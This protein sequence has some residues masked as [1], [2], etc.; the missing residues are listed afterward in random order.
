MA[1]TATNV[2]AAKPATGG[3][4]YIADTTA[5]M[6]T[7]ANGTLGT[8]WTALGYI[9]EDGL[10]NSNT[11][12]VNIINAWGGD[13]V[14]PV[15]EAKEDTFQFQLME[16]LN[17]DVLKAVYGDAKVSGTL[18]A[19]ITVQANNNE[20]SNK[21]FV[22]DM[23]MRN[24]AL[25]RIV[26]P[27]ASITDLGDITYSDSDAVGYEVTLSAQADASGNTHYEYIKAASGAT[28]G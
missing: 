8:G 17:V 18:A 24:G 10:T 20:V 6:P 4:I 11:P 1:Q 21:A 15:Y 25:K 3:A 23:I 14:L 7:T 9:S 28:N 27:N 12:N 5:T 26:I 16:V 13:P 19:G 2:S 22:F